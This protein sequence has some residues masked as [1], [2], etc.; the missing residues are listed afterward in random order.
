MPPSGSCQPE[1][2]LDDRGQRVAMSLIRTWPRVRLR[3]VEGLQR[4]RKV[5]AVERLAWRGRGARKG[6]RGIQGGE[7]DEAMARDG[8]RPHRAGGQYFFE[9]RVHFLMTRGVKAAE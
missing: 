2:I 5:Q 7:S 6:W 8:H 3:G 1:R 4:V 9:K